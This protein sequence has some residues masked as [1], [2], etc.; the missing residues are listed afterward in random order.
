LLTKAEVE[1]DYRTALAGVRE[2][3]A[4]V[5]LLLE[6]EGELDRRSMVNILI[7]PDWVSLRA[8]LMLALRPYPDAAMAVSR[9]IAQKRSDLDESI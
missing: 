2:A 6:V 8:A 4:C 1:G 7:A 9:A 5:E 3:R